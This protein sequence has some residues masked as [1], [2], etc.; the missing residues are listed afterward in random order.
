MDSVDIGKVHTETVFFHVTIPIICNK[1]LDLDQ[2][3]FE[4]CLL[5][6]KTGRP[7]GLLTVR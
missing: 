2:P 1:R 5:H 7:F 6:K 4:L 3:N